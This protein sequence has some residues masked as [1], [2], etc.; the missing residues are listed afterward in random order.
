MKFECT[1][2]ALHKNGGAISG[3]G[4]KSADI[5]I[6]GMC[7]GPKEIE[8]EIPFVG[9]SGRILND[10]LTLAGLKREDIYITNVAKCFSPPGRILSKTFV[11]ICSNEYLKKEIEEIKPKVIIV[12][13]QTACKFFGGK[14][15]SNSYFYE[16]KYNCYVLITHHPSRLLRT[17][18]DKLYNEFRQAFVTSK[19]LVNNICTKKA[20]IK[21]KYI[22]QITEEDLNVFDEIVSIDI[23]T[24]GLNFL[25]DTIISIGISDGKNNIGIPLY[26][27]IDK[28]IFK[29]N[30]NVLRSWLVTRKIIGHNIKFDYKFLKKEGIELNVV[31]DTMLAHFLIDRNASHGLKEIA[32]KYLHTKL[33]KGTIDFENDSI[34]VKERSIYA[35]NDAWMTYEI[36]KKFKPIIDTHYSKVYY[37]V[38]I[39]TLH[40]LANAEYRGVKINRDYVNDY[41]NKFKYDLKAL[42]SDIQND[43]VVKDFCNKFG[44]DEFNIRSPKQLKDMIY[45]YLGLKHKENNTAER[46]LEDLLEKYPQHLFLQKV[47]RYRHLYKSYRTYL[48]NLIK[49]SEI[50][51]RIHCQY[52]QTRVPTGRLSSSKPN[53]QNIPKDGDLAKIVRK[54]FVAKEGYTLIESDFKQAEFRALA[55]Y[56][57]DPHMIQL[58]NDGKDIHKII[59][60]ISYLKPENQVTD[61][62]RKIAKTIVF[63]LMYGRGAKSIAESLNI[64]L[65]EASDI[66]D[67]FFKTFRKASLWMKNVQSFVKKNGYIKTLAGRKIVLPEVYSKD[68]ER[69]AYVLRCAVNYPIQG[70]AADMTNLAG[71]FI[72]RLLKEKKLDAHLIMNIHDSLI[73]ECK[74]EIISEVKSI[75]KH[76]MEYQVKEAFQFKVKLEIDMNEGDNLSFS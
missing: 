13:G 32:L 36:Y 34:D 73:V 6:L 69:V 9:P 39:P 52:N 25:E 7:P 70:I 17:Y 16:E 63:G 57:K 54:A 64:P 56:C 43:Q 62:E 58:I 41:I 68:K 55:H 49:F 50:D 46:T 35:S 18:N 3:V 22:E 44:L 15:I 76:A 10:A 40:W 14:F 19:D 12:L 66:R 2:C 65:K 75:I 29:N 33:T 45:I 26:N 23:E 11:R 53:L 5:F 67:N 47:V 20:E 8:L 60:S 31:F 30:K 48:K 28:L 61:L 71:A 27:N 21:V 24:T 72:Y 4:P 59:A 51:G 38:M 42:E 74:K 1:K 37:L